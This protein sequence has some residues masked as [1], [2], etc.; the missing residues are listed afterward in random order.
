SLKPPDTTAFTTSDIDFRVDGDHLY[1][2]RIDFKGDAIS[3]K[4]RG[5]MNFSSDVALTFYAL[6][7][8]DELP[9]PV[10][11]ELFRAASRQIM[12]IHV[13]GKMGA[14]QITRDPFP[15]VNQAWQTLTAE[16]LPPPE[17]TGRLQ[18]HAA[19]PTHVPAAPAPNARLSA[20]PG[21]APAS[22]PQRPSRP[23]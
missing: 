19:Q 6:V 4:G 20:P 13:D 10:I 15:G 22:V 23:Y 9:I 21:A 12:L 8:R 1:F 3:L 2:D 14:P 11:P 7:G 16:L 17:R 18:P 5:E